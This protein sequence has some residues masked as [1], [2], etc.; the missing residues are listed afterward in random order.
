MS[1]PNSAGTD[2]DAAARLRTASDVIA[3]TLGESAVLIRLSTNRIYELN[4]TGARV[5]DLV[6]KGATRDDIVAALQQEFEGDRV[7]ISD[8]VDDLLANLRAEG[9]M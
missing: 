4:A 5:W 3:R 6:V 7:E 9:L 2:P 8:A 1:Y